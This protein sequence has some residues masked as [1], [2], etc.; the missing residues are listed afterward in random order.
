MYTDGL[1]RTGIVGLISS[2]GNDNLFCPR[3]SFRVGRNRDK[4]KTFRRPARQ[5][6]RIVNRTRIYYVG[7]VKQNVCTLTR[8]TIFRSCIYFTTIPG[9]D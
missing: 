2:R 1:P 3:G 7:H 8:A 6:L 9:Y 4:R 5:Q